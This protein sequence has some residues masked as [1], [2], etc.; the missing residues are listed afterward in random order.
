MINAGNTVT[1]AGGASPPSS[2]TTSSCESDVESP[3]SVPS[4][5]F[6]RQ[7]QRLGDDFII[8]KPFNQSAS[9]MEDGKE[10]EKS[11]YGIYAYRASIPNNNSNSMHSAYQQNTAST[12]DS[13]ARYNHQHH[14]YYNINSQS[15]GYML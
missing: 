9:T 4:D 3:L 8:Y 7:Q 10:E 12:T 5:H 6:Q 1:G 14:D 13:F 15:S 11:N 2:P